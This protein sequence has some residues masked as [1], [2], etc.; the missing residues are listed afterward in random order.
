MDTRSN[1]ISRSRSLIAFTLIG[2]M[3]LASWSMYARAQDS[4]KPASPVAS[5]NLGHAL[6][7]SQAFRDVSKAVAPSVVSIKSTVAAEPRFSGAPGNGQLQPDLP[8]DEDMLRRFF[9]GEIPEGLEMR[10]GGPNGQP[11]PRER[12]GQGTGVIAREDGYVITNNH[13]VDGA[14][15]ITVKLSDDREYPAT[16]VGT[17]AE[18]DLAV[19]KI[20]A[21]GLIPATFGDSDSLEV[22]EWVLAMGSPFGLEHT[23]TAGIV[24]AKGR[25]NMGLA[26]FEDFIQTDAAINPGNSGGP[27]VN[28]YGQVIG[29]NTAISTRSGSNAGVG[30]AIPSTMVKSVMDSIIESGTVQRGWLGVSIQDLSQQAREYTG[31]D[32]QGVLIAEVIPNTPAAA[33]G[34]NDG[35]IVTSINKAPVASR[36]QLLNVVAM[37]A[38]GEHADL[39]IVRGGQSQ[40]VTV[41]LGDRSAQLANAAPSTGGR[42]SKPAPTAELGLTL[43]PLTPEIA[44]QLGA[45]D[46]KGVVVAQL[47][48]NG[49]AAKAGIQ[50]GDVISMV[51][52]HA[53][54][55]TEEFQNALEVAATGKPI[56]LQ[57]FRGGASQF[58]FVKK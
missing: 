14:T 11:Q 36:N 30:F 27:L 57:V 34:L 17:D 13:V 38:P 12:Q 16:V 24:S 46:R 26:T 40:N 39:K 35:D 3:S 37:I 2:G 45:T 23:V 15:E 56:R 8:L 52:D 28:L 47:D 1:R 18:S 54:A 33:A 32:G 22:G 4:T 21:S 6:A 5:E 7:L 31:Y 29:I 58:V 48:P 55:N 25:A 10:P 9:G 50:A 53:I 49:P 42:T 41:T 20:E 19:I 51:N 44:R 43:Q